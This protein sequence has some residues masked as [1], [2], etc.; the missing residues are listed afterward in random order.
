MKF[1]QH[2]VFTVLIASVIL[3]CSAPSHSE[4]KFLIPPGGVWTATAGPGQLV[5]PHGTK[6]VPAEPDKPVTLTVLD[7][8]K[9]I[10]MVGPDFTGTLT[11]S[12]GG[13][14]GAVYNGTITAPKAQISLKGLLYHEGMGGTAEMV[15]EMFRV[16]SPGCTFTRP[17]H[18]KWTKSKAKIK[19][20]NP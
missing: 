17:F 14:H 9:T 20:I 12:E 10:K 2:F 7:Q 18:M 19:V 5:C 6:S 15:G 11:R 4:A 13:A 1:P 8:G 16:P 3:F